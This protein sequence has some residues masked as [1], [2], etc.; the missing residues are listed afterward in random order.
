MIAFIMD[1]DY[2]HTMSSRADRLDILQHLADHKRATPLADHFRIFEPTVRS[3]L[4][5]T[6]LRVGS[7]TS[8]DVG[9][10]FARICKLS[11]T[12][13]NGMCEERDRL[14]DLDVTLI[15]DSTLVK[16]EGSVGIDE[17]T[18]ARR[19]LFLEVIVYPHQ[20]M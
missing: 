13:C 2:P 18:M 19:C 15:A 8:L 10:H 14:V 7:P 20:H 3:T 12:V 5:D 9:E 6:L 1:I 4:H 11:V 17:L 16:R